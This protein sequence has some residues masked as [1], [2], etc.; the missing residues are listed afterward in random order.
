MDKDEAIRERRPMRP[1]PSSA[2]PVLLSLLLLAVG[3]LWTMDRQS[4]LQLA[5]QPLRLLERPVCA[6]GC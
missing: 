1:A 3:L 4:P 6:E 2:L 5:E